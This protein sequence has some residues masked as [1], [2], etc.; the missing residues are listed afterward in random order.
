MN[1][2]YNV[3]DTIT[4]GAYN[5]FI[6]RHISKGWYHVYHPN[7]VTASCTIKEATTRIRWSWT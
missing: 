7:N 2:Q 4:N 6:V 3:G 5:G 1:T